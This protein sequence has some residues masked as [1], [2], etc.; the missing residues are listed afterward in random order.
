MKMAFP[1][2][3]QRAVIAPPSKYRSRSWN[4]LALVRHHR[5]TATG[6]QPDRLQAAL[7]VRRRS[8]RPDPEIHLLPLRPRHFRQALSHRAAAQASLRV[9]VAVLRRAP[10]PAESLFA[11]VPGRRDR[12][13]PE[14]EAAL[15]P[16]LLSRTGSSG[17]ANLPAPDHRCRVPFHRPQHRPSAATLPRLVLPPSA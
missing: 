1:E 8:V 13:H 16:F 5:P 11:A 10:L 12:R 6:D 7:P 2:R 9:Q 4:S 15:A 14:I 3:A 17:L